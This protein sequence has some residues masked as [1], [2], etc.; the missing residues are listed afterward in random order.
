MRGS[1]SALEANHSQEDLVVRSSDPG[2]VFR[3]KVP[4][5]TPVQQDLDHL[6]LQR[7]DFQPEWGG[8]DGV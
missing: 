3:A 7:L 8:H 4:R 5:Y 2:E 6:G 1:F